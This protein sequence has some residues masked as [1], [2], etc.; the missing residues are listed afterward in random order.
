M[1]SFV[2]SLQLAVRA[3]A[4]AAIAVALAGALA[5]PLPLY[6]MIAAVIVTDLSPA[7]TRQLALARIVG[8]IIGAVAGAGLQPAAGP[9]WTMAP[10]IFLSMLACHAIGMKDGAKL[11]GYV[12]GIVLLE[13]GDAPWAYALDRFTETLLGIAVAVAVSFVPKLLRT[14]SEA[15]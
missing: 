3:A 15:P 14:G 4:A 5:L 11:A 1:Q 13:H 9:A 7:K 8:T 2:P 10:G 12:C 6:A